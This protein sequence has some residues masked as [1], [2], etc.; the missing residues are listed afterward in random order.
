MVGTSLTIWYKI[1]QVPYSARNITSGVL[2]RCDPHERFHGLSALMDK[3]MYPSSNDNL[4]LGCN[5]FAEHS[6]TH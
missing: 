2:C 1:H 5:R 4:H 3:I 6:L